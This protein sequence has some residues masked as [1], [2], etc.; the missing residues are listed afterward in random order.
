MSS[1]DNH[2]TM[3]TTTNFE[4][5]AIMKAR[6]SEW[7]QKYRFLVDDKFIKYVLVEPGT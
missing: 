2:A 1:Q 5:L 3:I 4:L 6:S 7:M